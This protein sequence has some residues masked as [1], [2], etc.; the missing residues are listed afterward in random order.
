[1]PNKIAILY[2]NVKNMDEYYDFEGKLTEN[3]AL[4]AMVSP[5]ASF[6]K[7]IAIHMTAKNLY[8]RFLTFAKEHNREGN[9]Y[10]T[11]EEIQKEFGDRTELEAAVKYML[12]KR[13]IKEGYL[14]APQK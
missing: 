10:L 5:D 13:Y 11:L 2:P 1:M 4:L 9:M 14:E 7:D 3:A 12:E 8:D 6:A